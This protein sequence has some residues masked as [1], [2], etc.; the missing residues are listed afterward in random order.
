MF[1]KQAAL[2]EQSLVTGGVSPLAANEMMNAVGNC[3][4]PL[5][6][7]GP[8]SIDYTPAD[9]K[10]V[11]PTLR[12][13]RFP[14]LDPVQKVG[15]IRKP[16]R[17]EEE[18]KPPGDRREPPPRDEPRPPRPPLQETMRY[19]DSTGITGIAEGPYIRVGAAG[20]TSALVGLRAYGTSGQVAT[21]GKNVILGKTLEIRSARRDVLSVES[22][23]S[24]LLYTLR[25]QGE[26]YEVI[27]DVTVEDQEIIFTRKRCFLFAAEDADDL[28]VEMKRLSYIKD[29]YIGDDA[30]EFPLR[31]TYVLAGYDGDGDT[32]YLPLTDCED[33]SA[34]T[35]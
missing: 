17:K 20:P 26:E 8:V 12:K 24:S 13:Y 7:R 32:I 4:Q 30:I 33:I 28:R 14:S 34:P 3:A 1:T 29:A 2:I 11:T 5:V 18:Q 21:F 27:T 15:P 31:E 10:F 16:P 19:G 23:S 9:L 6:H 25:P 22:T 35:P